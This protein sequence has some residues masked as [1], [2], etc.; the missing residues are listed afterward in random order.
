MNMIAL[1]TLKYLNS[2]QIQWVYKA[3]LIWNRTYPF[4]PSSHF[5]HTTPTLF[6]SNPPLTSSLG[7]MF[8]LLSFLHDKYFFQIFFP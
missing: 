5:L 1:Q 8:T 3:N 7:A 4:L 6:M 2:L